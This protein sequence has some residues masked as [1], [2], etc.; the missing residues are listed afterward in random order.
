MPMLTLRP[1]K[2]NALPPGGTIKAVITSDGM[3]LRAA[4]W[5]PAGRTVRGTVC[6][7]Q[8]RAEFIEK[9]YE[10]IGDLRRRGFF[11]VAFDWRGQGDSSRQVRDRH[12]GHVARFD[13]YRRDLKAVTEAILTPLAPAPHFCLAHSMGGAIAI[14]GAL[15]GWLP[16]ERLVSVA[17]MLSIRMV[18]NPAFVSVA[19]RALQRLGFGR[20]YVPS[21]ENIRWR[22]N[23]AFGRGDTPGLRKPSDSLATMPFPGNRLSNDPVRYARNAAAAV[24]VGDGAVGDPTIAWLASAFRAMARLREPGIAPRIDL[25]I[26]VVA[27][28]ADPVCGTP[29]TE[30]FATRLAAGHLIVLPG[31]RHEILSETDAIRSDF[32]AAFDAFI[33]GSDAAPSQD[34]E[35]A[36]PAVMAASA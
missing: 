5:R 13:D 26:L 1:T 12:K 34:E 25:P 20:A 11:V 18:D 35:E 19:S 23:K 9:Y 22:V 14:T 3:M 4:Y 29:T 32:W 24:A 7:L 15:D 6:L 8:G 31:A 28:G 10:T 27:A 21:P 17:P 36:I 33:P 2:G 30:R 16:F